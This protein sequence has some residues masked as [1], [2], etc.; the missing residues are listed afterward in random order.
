MSSVWLSPELKA[1]RAGRMP[2][3]LL[4]GSSLQSLWS[5]APTAAYVLRRSG[6]KPLAFNGVLLIEHVSREED[7]SLRRHAIRLYESTDGA[8]IVEIILATADDS[9]LAHAIAT[10]VE[11]LADAEA[12]LATYDPAGQAALAVTVDEPT[13][14]AFTVGDMAERLRAE[15]ARLRNDFEEARVA[16]FAAARTEEQETTQRVN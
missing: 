10:E 7:E 14:D 8:F 1:I 9:I 6:A 2:K 11:S 12:F 4:S 3:A 15:A 16:V 5:D 13:Q